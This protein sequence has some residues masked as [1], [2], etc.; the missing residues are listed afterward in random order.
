MRREAQVLSNKPGEL[1]I[2]LYRMLASESVNS[3]ALKTTLAASGEVTARL[4]Y[5]QLN[6]HLEH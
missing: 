4:R 5:S 1:E 3:E 2:A 6:S